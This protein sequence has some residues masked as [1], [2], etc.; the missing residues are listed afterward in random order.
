MLSLQSSFTFCGFQYSAFLHQTVLCLVAYANARNISDLNH[1]FER[2]WSNWNSLKIESF[3]EFN[4]WNCSPIDYFTLHCIQCSF[5]ICYSILNFI[6]RYLKSGVH[7]TRKSVRV[8]LL[9]LLW[10]WRRLQSVKFRKADT[11]KTV[12]IWCVKYWIMWLTTINN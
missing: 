5:A 12:Y 6:E 1:M 3:G 4:Y 10:S 9:W 11:E 8:M 7:F 2:T